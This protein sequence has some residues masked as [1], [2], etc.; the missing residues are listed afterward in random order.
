MERTEQFVGIDI[1]KRQLDLAIH[2]TYDVL[3]PLEARSWGFEIG[4][5]AVAA[6][7]VPAGAAALSGRGNG[8]S[9]AQILDRGGQ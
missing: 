5:R 7:V 2:I 1:S 6:P 8:P 3:R 4:S 9:A